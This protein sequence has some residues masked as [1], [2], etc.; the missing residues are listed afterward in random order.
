M[1]ERAHTRPAGS[2]CL[3]LWP[4]GSRFLKRASLCTEGRAVTVCTTCLFR[5]HRAATRARVSVKALQNVAQSLQTGLVL[6]LVSQTLTTESN[7][8]PNLHGDEPICLWVKPVPDHK[9]LRQINLSLKTVPAPSLGPAACHR[10]QLPILSL[11]ESPCLRANISPP[12]RPL[13]PRLGSATGTDS[14]LPPPGPLL[15]MA[16]LSAECSG[17]GQ[18]V[19]KKGGESNGLPDAGGARV[20]SWPVWPAAQSSWI[21]SFGFVE[22]EQELKDA[23]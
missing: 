13:R 14:T 23:P 4:L 11:T 20:F 9:T 21:V 7:P 18:Q 16:V 19:T 12:G 6:Q 17:R 10:T 8:Q 1:S 5:R 15:S 22:A 3:P 2:P